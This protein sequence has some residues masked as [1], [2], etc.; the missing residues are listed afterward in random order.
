MAQKNTLVDDCGVVINETNPLDVG[1]SSI[2]LMCEQLHQIIEQL[3]FTNELLKEI[4]K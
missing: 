2:E 3:K 1:G 4:A